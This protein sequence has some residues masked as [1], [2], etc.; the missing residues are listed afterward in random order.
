MIYDVATVINQSAV[1]SSALR[2]SCSAKRAGFAINSCS[3]VVT[4]VNSR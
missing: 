3:F 1:G 4:S 2:L